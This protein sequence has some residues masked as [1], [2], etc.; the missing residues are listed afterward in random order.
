MQLN[1]RWIDLGQMKIRYVS[2][3]R[4]VLVLRNR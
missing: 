3:Q 1:L 2:C 4:M